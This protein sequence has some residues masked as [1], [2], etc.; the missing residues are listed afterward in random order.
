MSEARILWRRLDAEGH[1]SCDLLRLPDGWR[2]AGM[3]V[4]GHEGQACA[5]NYSAE[6][7]DRWRTR[8]ATATG[9]LGTKK[10]DFHIMA[11]SGRWTLNG[12]DQ[13]Q[14]AGCID[15]DLS[16]TPA[17]NLLPLRRHALAVG[18]ETPAP[19]AYLAFPELRLERLEQTYRRIDATKYA[20][21]ASAHGYDDVLEVSEAGFIRDYPGLW[22]A[23]G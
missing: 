10:L 19:A 9:S 5:V 11:E 3:A 4:F 2:L 14:V 15:V 7:D 23:V 1:D 8:S 21:T 17:T 13:P 18:Q 16:F 6:C 12:V 22:K 20:Y